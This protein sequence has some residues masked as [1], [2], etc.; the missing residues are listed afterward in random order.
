MALGAGGR[1]LD[2]AAQSHSQRQSGITARAGIRTG[3]RVPWSRA[4]TN[5]LSSRSIHFLIMMDLIVI[6]VAGAA[7]LVVLLAAVVLLIRWRRNRYR[8]SSHALLLLF[9]LIG[10]SL[11]ALMRFVL[12]SVAHRLAIQNI[13]DSGGSVLFREDYNRDPTNLYSDP[14][15]DSA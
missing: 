11:S 6:A 15:K 7:S 1:H 14:R 5:A 9:V 3:R 8:F 4:A 2:S 10:C 12:P 13:Y